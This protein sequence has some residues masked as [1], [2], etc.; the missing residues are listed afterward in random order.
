MIKRLSLI[1]LCAAPLAGMAQAHAQTAAPAFPSGTWT[2]QDENASISTQSL[3]DR[4]YV[5]G[6]HIGWTSHEGAVPDAIA[7]FGHALLGAGDQRISVSLTQKIFTPDATA[8]IDPPVNDEPYAGA[9]LG[10]FA[11]I[12][13]TA[14][15]RTVVGFD[16]GVVGRDAGAEL[17]QNGFH[18]VIGQH[19]THGWAYQLPSEPAFDVLASRTWRVGVAKFGNGLEVDALPQLAGMVGTTEAYIEPAVSLRI[20]EGLNSDYGAPL[21]S[22]G[23]SGSDAYRQTRP[24]VWYVFGGVA[25]Q[26]V[27]HD[28]FLSGA[29][30]ESSRAV[31]PTHAVGQLDAGVAI[32]WHGVRFSYTQVVQTRRYVGQIGGIHEYGSLAVSAKF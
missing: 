3:T 17:V 21:L 26:F 4:Y 14:N 9:L 25:G 12:Q 32:I 1:A 15:S 23:P 16:A 13:D 11:L 24:F 29:D 2:I 18:A 8:A 22:P 31:N 19:G 6:L 7:N 30:F 10:T 20:G 5:N 27:G 28:E